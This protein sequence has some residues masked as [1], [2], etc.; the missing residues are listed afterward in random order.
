M[1]MHYDNPQLQ[2]G[3]EDVLNIITDS[4]YVGRIDSSGIKLSY[5]LTPSKY[6][7][8]SLSI[9]STALPAL[10]IP[11]NADNFTYDALCSSTCLDKVSLDNIGEIN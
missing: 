6:Q 1:E 10:I 9:G 4:L 5:S 11:P 8:A 3:K 7:A 2:S